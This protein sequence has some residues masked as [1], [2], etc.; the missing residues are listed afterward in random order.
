[1]TRTLFFL[2]T[3][4][5]FTSS[6]INYKNI[7]DI[8]A[9][10]KIQK[11]YGESIKDAAYPE[12]DEISFNLTSVNSENNKLQWKEINGEPYV[13]V[14]SW[15]EE[16]KYYENDEKTGFYNTYKYPIWVTLAPYAKERCQEKP[17]GKREGLDLRLK[18]LFG[19][20]PSSEQKWFVEFWVRPADLFRPCADQEINDKECSLCF[21]KEVSDEH[22]KWINETRSGSYY[23]CELYDRYPWTQLGYTYDWNPKN[24]SNVGLS[25]FV[26]GANKNVIVKGAYPTNEYCG[27]K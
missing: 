2:A 1:M 12:K 26:I 4:L 21:A 16:R 10:P 19:L 18:Q 22:K 7:A 23:N 9:H 11:M 14:V 5:L 8:P 3:L 24:K 15:K 25:E 17:F 13:L 6:C 27:R 20:P